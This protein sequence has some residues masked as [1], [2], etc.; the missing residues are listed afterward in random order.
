[1]VDIYILDL[2][3]IGLLL[4]IVTLGSGW[5]SRL[6][7]SFA[8]IYLIVGVFLG[9][10]GLG[11]I[12]LR[13]DEF[14]NAELLERLTEFVVI[15]SVFSCGLKIVTLLKWRLWN[16]TL[17]LIAL[18]MPI[19]IFSLAAVGKLWLGMNWGEAILLGAILAPTDP[20][21][22]SEVQ[23][24][25]TNDDDELRFGL[26]SEGGL[27][28]ALAFPFVYF[29]IYALKD[30]NWH[31]WLGNW[32][33]V[34][35][36]WAIASGIVMGLIV[37]IAIVWIDKKIQKYRPADAVMEDFVAIST[38]LLTYS[39]TEIVN[40]Y[41]FLAVFVAGLAVQR[42]YTNP[43]K[44]LAQLEFIERL[45]KLLEVGLILI[46]GTILL[47]KPMF[48]Y[49]T[50]S[51]LVISLLFFVIRPV[52]VWIST[53]GKRPLNS[54]RRTF[55]P[56]TRLLFGWFGIRGIGSLYYLAYSLSNGLKGE[57]AEQIAWITYTTIVV[58]V[59]VHGI[60]ST[61]LMNWYES[62]IANRTKPN[63]HATID[64]FE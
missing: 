39:L 3:V 49:A 45:E 16:I 22:A 41:G 57:A 62:N 21:L 11:M 40:G 34:D 48:K 27:N 4:L 52:G 59:I 33:A 18:L 14:F 60:S 43:H 51:L 8:M 35:V 28:D 17:R 42:S 29:G 54:H 12:Q 55:N 2:L 24:T 31:N 64:E 38:I 30:S 9:P 36:I 58:S 6:P 46:L 7:L 1:M 47:W 56:V 44:P 13:R 19:S 32:V 15:V 5:I 26:T 10:Y 37:P 50:Q 53:I 61:P 63:I 25:D 23:L 20:V